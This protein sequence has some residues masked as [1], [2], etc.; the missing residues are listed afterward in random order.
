LLKNVKASHGVDLAYLYYLPF[1][2][3][4]TSKDNFHVQIVPL[5]LGPNQEFIDGTQFKEDLKKLNEY[6]SALSTDVLKTGLI[7]F[8]AYPPEDADF[9]VTRMWD[10][11]LPRWRSIKAEPKPER[12]VE[13][14]KQLVEEIDQLSQPSLPSHDKR[15]IDKVDYAQVVRMVLPRK[16]K[17]LRF[18]EKQI[19]QMYE[20]KSKQAS[21]SGKPFSGEAV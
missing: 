21:G 18:S 15:D 3:V 1:C 2:S 12:S 19:R 16:G 6:Y 9:F 14:E 8:A 4:F 11:F 20:Q 17:W 13:E 10:R 7:N 5:F